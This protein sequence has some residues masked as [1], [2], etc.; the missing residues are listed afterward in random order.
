MIYDKSKHDLGV[1]RQDGVTKVGFMLVKKNNQPQYAVFDDEYLAQQFFTGTPGYGSLPAEKEIAMRQDDWRS[2]FGLN[3]YDAADPKRYLSSRGMDLRFRGM[4]IPGSKP[5]ALEKST[6]VTTPNLPNNT[7]EADSD[8]LNGVGTH[9]RSNTQARTDTYSWQIN[10]IVNSYACQ[11]ILD[12]VPGGTYTVNSWYTSNGEGR[13]YIAIHDGVNISQGVERGGAIGTWEQS[14]VTKKLADEATRFQ[15]MLYNGKDASELGY[16]DD[17]QIVNTDYGYGPTNCFTE[18]ND[19]LYMNFGTLLSKLNNAGNGFTL[20]RGFA[21]NITALEPFVDD[22]LHIGIGT[23]N[24]GFYMNTGEA[25]TQY[26]AGVNTFQFL[27]RVDAASP[28]MWGNDSQFQIR[29]TT[30]PINANSWSGVTNVDSSYHNITDLL[31]RAGALF[32]MKEDMPYYLDSSGN[33][34]SD[35]APKLRALTKSTS[36]KGAYTDGEKI[37][38]PAGEQALLEIESDGTL[39]W[40]NPSDFCTNLPEFNGRVCAVTADDRYLYIVLDNGD[41]VYVFAGRDETIDG[42]TQWVWHPIAEVPISGCETAFVTSIPDK[43][44]FISSTNGSEPLYYMKLTGYGDV[45]TDANRNFATNVDFET[46]YLHGN[47]KDSKK[48]FPELS[49]L[50]GHAYNANRFYSA[51]Y[52]T[53]TNTTYSLIANYTGSTSSMYQTNYLPFTPSDYMIRLKFVA[54]TD[55]TNEAPILLNHKLKGLLYPERRGII[56]CS[57]KCADQIPLKDGTVDD[58]YD[59]TLAT[60]DEMLTATWPITLYD[61]DGNTKYVKPLPQSGPRWTALRDEKGRG[62]ERVYNLLLQE[63]ELG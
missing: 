5:I 39:T 21:T 46:P 45:L 51:Y 11:N 60:L 22:N 56:A 57:L 52:K 37:W 4:A 23:I 55:D 38:I 48:A 58:S 63:I 26:G 2:G 29:S 54:N 49:I 14:A 30:T 9:Q 42:S 6:M 33:V 31:S 1:L 18:H 15:I 3:V 12:F 17:A 20:L 34:Q 53:L 47:F 44:L 28:T 62:Q 36:G 40:R 27:Q 10:A 7:M 41:V 8:W 35:L 32:I 43:R 24:C 50:L 61:I 25:F 59:D 19:K 13:G 16:F